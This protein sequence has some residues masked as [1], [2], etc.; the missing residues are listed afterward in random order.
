DR[1]LRAGLGFGY[2]GKLAVG[3]ADRA[4]EALVR[5]EGVTEELE[6][7]IDA[8]AI[9]RYD[10]AA[11]FLPSQQRQKRQIAAIPPKDE[12]RERL[13]D[14]L[15]G[16]PF[17]KD[18]FD[19]FIEEA[20][21]ARLR[22]L[23]TVESLTDS[24]MGERLKAL[25]FEQ[26]GLWI[27]PILLH[28]VANE[29]MLSSL[30]RKNGHSQVIYLNIKAKAEEILASALDRVTPLL[31]LGVLAIYLLMTASYRDAWRPLRVLFP[32]L[33][34]VAVTLAILNISGI[35]LTLMHLVSLLLIIGLGLDY[36]L[37]YN[38]LNDDADEWRTT[39]KALWVSSFTTVMVFGI[40][41]FSNTPPLQAIG[42]TVGI[43][44][45]LSLLFGAFWIRR[46][47]GAERA[48]SA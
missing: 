29:A 4:E 32:T 38:R 5:S 33:S 21:Q 43:G 1:Q 20:S 8:G 17:R 34:A 39:F 11:A 24:Q 19:P 27:A 30:D 25:L 12:L 40:L 10:M 16:T 35:P 31:G 37:F 15:D 13:D 7:M 28:G 44:A 36:A 22:P 42:L 48:T 45:L 14:A 23:L 9:A 47:P 6:R 2:G 46:R 3:A 18:V 26:D 41:V